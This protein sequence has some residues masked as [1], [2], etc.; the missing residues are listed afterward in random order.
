MNSTNSKAFGCQTAVN[1]TANDDRKEDVSW[2]LGAGFPISRSVGVKASYIDSDRRNF[3]GNKSQTLS[4]G[5][6][7][8][9]H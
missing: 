8:S 9:W 4:L 5:L 1:G 3:T 6:S 2:A 7:A